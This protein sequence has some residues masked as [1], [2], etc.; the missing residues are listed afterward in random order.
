MKS[1]LNYRFARLV[2]AVLIVFALAC[3]PAF[4]GEPL[5]T[6]AAKP[7]AHKKAAKKAASKTEAGRTVTILHT[8]DVH[9]HLVPFDMPD[10][11]KKVGGAAR[12]YEIVSKVRANDPEALLFDAGDIFQGTPFYT[13]FK[14]ETDMLVHGACGYD[15]V[16]LGNH[17]L[18]DGL[19]NLLKQLEKVKFPMLCGNVFYSGTNKPVFP[20]FKIFK[21]KGLKIAVIGAIG[22]GSW[23][24]IPKKYT[25]GMYH[26]NEMK[27]ISRLASML[28][29]HVDLIVM[30]SHL[31]YDPDLEFAKQIK[32]VDVIIGGHTNTRVEAPVLVKNGADNGL[33]GSLVLQNFKWAVF[34]GR[35]DLKFGADNRMTGYSGALQPIDSKIRV[36]KGNPVQK[37]VAEY[38]KQIKTRVSQ[39]IGECRG[40]M[41][42][43]EDEKH[44]RALPLG[45]Y[46]CDSMTAFA[47]ADMAIINSGSIREPMLAGPVTISTIMSILPFD[48]S[49][50]TFELKGA[51]IAE[52]LAF[53]GSNYGKLSGYQ[54][55][56]ASFTLDARTGVVS[57]IMIG[58]KPLAPAKTYRVAT[59]SYIAEG[60]QN[61]SV[62]FKAGKN[63]SDNGFYMR[64][65]LIEY[66]KSHP[67]IVPPAPDRMKVIK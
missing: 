50:T 33:G 4:S 34:M 14:G 8:N 45:S 41:L 60:N 7:S 59:I 16:T 11:G 66:I 24:V 53:I 63:R 5:K 6:T 67:E 56:N 1:P 3:S 55:G 40:D 27:L 47:G 25:E 52:M 38:E 23:G 37:I 61:G 64:D 46:I 31:G 20:A 51:D 13:F 49:I 35:L 10:I 21:R 19:D 58:Q 18:D 28:R 17:D 57:D 54:Y 29:K 30:L 12:R 62:L 48:N 44:L 22:A 65:M 39:K 9:S 43:P 15:A 32:D 26:V 2:A 36:K 42:Y